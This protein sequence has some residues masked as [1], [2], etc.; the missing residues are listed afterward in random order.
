MLVI[1]LKNAHGMRALYFAEL[2]KSFALRKRLGFVD[3]YVFVV[4]IVST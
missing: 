2:L 4:N 1:F 3:K